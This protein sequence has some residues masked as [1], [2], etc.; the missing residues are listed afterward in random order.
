MIKSGAG[1]RQKSEVWVHFSYD[2]VANHTKCITED[3]QGKPCNTTLTG[4]NLTNMK[5]HLSRA[6]KDMHDICIKKDVALHA[7]TKRHTAPTVVPGSATQTDWCFDVWQARY[8]A[9]PA[10]SKEQLARGQDFTDWFVETSLP[11]RIVDGPASR[12]SVRGWILNSLFQVKLLH[13]YR[14]T[15]CKHG[16]CHCIDT[17]FGY[18][19]YTVLK[20]GISG[21][22]PYSPKFC[23]HHV[24][25]QSS[26]LWP[27]LSLAYSLIFSP[28]VPN[29]V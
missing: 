2:A 5:T 21:S 14:T 11:Y 3:S 6:H 29:G 4:K 7:E 19:Q 15:L 1:R 9:Y 24:H 23:R 28:N 13:F 22:T 12:K 16:I 8:T 27:S 26:G 17:I 18:I 25:V 10:M 20:F